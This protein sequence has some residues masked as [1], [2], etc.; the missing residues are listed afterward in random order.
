[1]KTFIVIICT[2]IL[3]FVWWYIAGINLD[4]LKIT[5]INKATEICGKDSQ[6][7]YTG[8]IRSI[9]GGFGGR[10]WYQCKINNIWYEFFIARRINSSEPQVYN[11]EQKTTFPNNFEVNNN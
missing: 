10:V 7:V 3:G 9:F 8:Y 5:G 2:M 1:M 11:F 4:Y 6:I